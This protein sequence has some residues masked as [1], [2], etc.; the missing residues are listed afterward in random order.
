MLITMPHRQCIYTNTITED[1][2]KCKDKEVSHRHRLND[3][4]LISNNIN[5][6]FKRRPIQVD[7]IVECN[8]VSSDLVQDRHDRDEYRQ[9]FSV[10]GADIPPAAIRRLTYL[11][12]VLFTLAF[13]HFLSII[14]IAH[15]NP[16][17][18]GTMSKP[19]SIVGLEK[20]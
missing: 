6:R 14:S 12:L 18:K 10:H 19:Q 3:N 5:V 2:C 1:Y 15:W 20:F 16:Q 4:I 8:C 13:S 11:P 9:A 7:S 17:S